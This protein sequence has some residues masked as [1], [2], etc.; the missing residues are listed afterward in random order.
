MWW[1]ILQHFGRECKRTWSGEVTAVV[2]GGIAGAATSYLRSGGKSSFTDSLIDGLV[3]ACIFFGI[4][5]FVHFLRSPWLERKS[6]GVP[7]SLADGVLGAF[8]FCL[9]AAAS[10]FICHLLAQDMRS[11]LTL[12]A[13]AD[14]GAKKSAEILALDSCKANLE[15]LTKPEPKDSLRRRTISIVNDLNLFWNQRPVP[16][17]PQPVQNPASDEDR[18]RKAKW[19]RYW[20]EAK[21]AYMN[22]NFNERVLG[23]VRA[24]K[25]LGIPTGYLEQSAE[26]QDR[27]IGSVPF[28]GASLDNC[29]GFM[30]DLCQLRE[31]A[32]HVNAEDKRIDP[33]DF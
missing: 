15:I 26:Q 24:Y 20:Q 7:P 27:L 29:V 5:V 21:V 31:L 28:G 33:P 4:Y 23:I 14:E 22:R 16:P 12:H 13:P 32:F 1:A 25:N 2:V 9:L 30:S 19:D 10:M 17:Q 18:A 11:E 8:L 3:T 6:E